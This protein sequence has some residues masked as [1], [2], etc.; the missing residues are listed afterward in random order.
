MTLVVSGC[1]GVKAGDAKQVLATQ[2][3]DATFYARSFQGA[4]TAS[5]L[6]FD[7]RKALA[8]HRSYPFGTVA[9]VT[10]PANGKSVQVVIVDRGP[11]GNNRR[12]SAI[13]DLSRSAAEQLDMIRDGQIPIRLEVL[14]WGDGEHWK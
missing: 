7:N 1:D 5:G 3:G 10:N 9:R 2:T 6:K 12:Q 8:A 14:E 13:I 11:H 4:R